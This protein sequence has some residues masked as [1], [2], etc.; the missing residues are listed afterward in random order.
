MYCI[1]SLFIYIYIY[2]CILRYRVWEIQICVL[3]NLD[4]CMYMYVFV[5]RIC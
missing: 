2:T 4:I 1:P 3:Y 5:V